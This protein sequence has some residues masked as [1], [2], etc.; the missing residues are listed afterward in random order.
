MGYDCVC[1][2]WIAK[3]NRPHHTKL[4]KPKFNFYTLAEPWGRFCQQ[5]DGHA[6]L[7][8]FWTSNMEW[9]EF[10]T[11]D[12]SIQS[13]KLQNRSPDQTRSGQGFTVN[14]L[15]LEPDPCNFP[16]YWISNREKLKIYYAF[17]QTAH[18]Q[19]NRDIDVTVIKE[20]LIAVINFHKFIYISDFIIWQPSPNQLVDRLGVHWPLLSIFKNFVGNCVLKCI[21]DRNNDRNDHNNNK[22][23]LCFILLPLA[24]QG[25]LRQFFRS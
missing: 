1:M 8:M 22:K 14:S 11:T 3:P 18:I 20:L 15:M 10:L 12:V 2:F 21:F 17:I 19:L 16:L 23:K 6:M 9:K 5:C 4:Q 7:S 24:T 13:L 25:D